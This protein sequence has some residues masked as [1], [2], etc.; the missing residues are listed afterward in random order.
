MSCVEDEAFRIERAV[1]EDYQVFA[2]IIQEVWQNM[3][4]KEWYVA[5]NAEYT[6]KMLNSGK[7]RGYKAIDLETGAVAGIFM[8][9]VPGMEPENMGYDIG[10][11]EE[12]LSLVAHMD[13]VAILPRYRGHRLQRRL[14]EAAESDLRREGYRYLMCTVHPDNC[15]SRNNVIGQGYRSMMVKEKYGGYVREVFLKQVEG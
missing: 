2:H 6:H 9:V 5:D 13:S 10:L 8:A 12:E 15:Y 14:M 1:P 3:P 11:P 7:G 4:K